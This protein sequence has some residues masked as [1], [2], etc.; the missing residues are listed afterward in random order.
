VK[1]EGKSKKQRPFIHGGATS[2]KAPRDL[3]PVV[4]ANIKKA[5]VL[6][7]P[8]SDKEF[9]KIR[10]AK[11]EGVRASGT[12]RPENFSSMAVVSDEHRLGKLP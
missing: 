8:Q 6:G 3:D 7:T 9:G 11:W 1:G 5:R 2:P 10:A 4:L 12:Q